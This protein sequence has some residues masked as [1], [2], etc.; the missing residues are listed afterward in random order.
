M[1]FGIVLLRYDVR[2]EP[3]FCPSVSETVT[4]TRD[5]E[6]DQR[7]SR[8]QNTD[9]RLSFQFSLQHPSPLSGFQSPVQFHLRGL[10]SQTS[11][12]F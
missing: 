9:T 4:V 2:D 8:T 10:A 12:Y 3:S 7:S 6:S 1:S 11:P 5:H